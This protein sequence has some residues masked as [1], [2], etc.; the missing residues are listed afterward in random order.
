MQAIVFPE[1]GSVELTTIPDPECGPGEVVLEVAT[2]GICGTDLHVHHGQYGDTYPIVPG[3]EF[4][5][6]LVEV[7]ADVEDLRVGERVTADPNV[8]CTH[9]RFCRNDQPNHCLNWKGMGVTINGSCAQYI[10][11]PARNCYSVPDGLTDS[12]AAF[13]EPLACVAYALRRLR[14]W[15]GDKVLILGAGPM[16]LLLSQALQHSTASQVVTVEKVA[17]RLA[18]AEQLGATAAVAAGPDQ[19][20]AL[21]ELAPFGFN[22]VIDATG[23]PAVIEKAFDYLAPRGQFLQFGVAPPDA[24]VRINPSKFFKNDWQLLGSFAVCLSFQPAIE[25]LSNGIIRTDP[26]VSHS[27]ELRNFETLFAQFEAGATL[28]AQ[29]RSNN[30]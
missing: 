11:V 8:F 27:A 30:E 3:H 26:L 23:V 29:I 18:V 20:L 21:T 17:D 5:G 7:G 16:G 2:T 10:K 6:T 13:I 4:S 19:D 9:C 28:K 15:P 22:I 14:V 12:Q 24:T 25:W 1:V